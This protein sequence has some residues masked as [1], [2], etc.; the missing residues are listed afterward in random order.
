MVQVLTFGID[1]MGDNQI[2]KFYIEGI[3]DSFLPD[4]DNLLKEMTDML[5]EL[6]FDTN[7]EAGKFD[8][9]ILKIEKEN[10]K[11]VIEGK[12]D[13]KDF[14]AFESCISKMYGENGFGLYKYGKLE[15]IDSITAQ[16]LAEHYQKLIQTA[17]IDIFV[18]GNLENADMETILRENENIKKLAPRS[19][20]YILNNEYT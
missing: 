11:Q 13:D 7:I 9:N 20:N 6:V 10:L 1:K 5:L 15:D 16:S 12:I 4:K 2:L 3:N 18:S 14:Y 17:K 8:E 19:E